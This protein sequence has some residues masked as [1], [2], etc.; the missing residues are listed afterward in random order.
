M[1][2]SLLNCDPN[3]GH[4]LKQNNIL[5]ALPLKK[6]GWV[7]G[8]R[9]TWAFADQKY[10]VFHKRSSSVSPNKQGLSVPLTYSPEWAEPL[11]GGIMRSHLRSGWVLWRLVCVPAP[12]T[13]ITPPKYPHGCWGCFS[14]ALCLPI[15][16]SPRFSF[17]TRVGMSVITSS[18]INTLLKEI[19]EQALSTVCQGKLQARECAIT[20]LWGCEANPQSSSRPHGEMLLLVGG[21][22]PQQ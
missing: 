6:V 22:S 18:T 2:D 4:L 10:E 7:D 15:I 21:G 5:Y 19:G 1:K 20:S 17:A 9:R 8:K 3:G 12:N 16:T 13:L 11:N 14:L